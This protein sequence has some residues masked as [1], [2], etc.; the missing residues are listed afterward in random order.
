MDV[1][2][3]HDTCSCCRT[4]FKCLDL[5]HQLGRYTNTVALDRR[6]TL[7]YGS[8]WHVLS[9]KKHAILAPYL[10]ITVRNSSLI[11]NKITFIQNRDDKCYQHC[12]NVLTSVSSVPNGVMYTFCNVRFP[13]Y[14]S[15]L[16]CS[17][18]K[19]IFSNKTLFFYSKK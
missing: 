4:F 19:R 1:H 16:F 17:T 13:T 3:Y 12:I 11:Y 8:S 18:P 10:V 14:I 9:L 6:I 15:I 2:C 7:D 5:W